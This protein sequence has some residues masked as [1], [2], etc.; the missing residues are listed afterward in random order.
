MIMINVRQHTNLV[1]NVC[2]SI[3]IFLRSIMGPKTIKATR[4]PNVKLLEKEA[5]INASA[6]EHTEMKKANTIITP[7]DKD[8]SCPRA[9]NI[10]RGIAICDNDPSIAPITKYFPI[11]KNSWQASRRVLI[12]L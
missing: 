3:R 8:E 7:M 10:S 4:E 1:R 9:N 11:S 5:A 6:A 12:H 2:N